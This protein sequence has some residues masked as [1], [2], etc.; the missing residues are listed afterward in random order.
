MVGVLTIGSENP[1]DVRSI[2]TNYYIDNYK[3]SICNQYSLNNTPKSIADIN[4]DCEAFLVGR[5]NK[6]KI[7]Y[8]GCSDTT[9]IVVSTTSI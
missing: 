2:H 4:L 1:I 5:K 8:G 9:Y 7:Q 6:Q 3:D